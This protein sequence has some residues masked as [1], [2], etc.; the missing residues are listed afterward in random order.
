MQSTLSLGTL[1]GIKLRIHISWLVIFLL[2]TFSLASYFSMTQVQWSVA[3]RL[4][5]AIIAA[6]LFFSSVVIHELAHSLLARRFG[7]PVRDITL[8]LFGGVSQIESEAKRPAEEFWIA[9]VGPLTSI[10]L[11]GLAYLVFLVAGM[12]SFI[13]AISFWLASV[14]LGL[15]IFNLLPAFPLDGGRVLRGLLWWK[16]GDNYRATRIAANF[17]KAI[18]ILLIASGFLLYLRT[19]SF[20]GMWLSFIGWFL[21]NGA[22]AGARQVESDETLKQI[23]AREV[24]SHDYTILSP[25]LKVSD[26][27]ESYLLRSG[28]RCFL[29]GENGQSY[30]LITADDLKRVETGQWQ[31][32][33]I[34][35]LMR[36]FEHIYRATPDIT[37]DKLL[38]I[39]SKENLDYVPVVEDGR[40]AGIVS[41]EQLLAV[42][43]ARKEFNP[44]RDQDRLDRA[45]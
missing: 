44:V 16:T 25:W 15:A 22:R 28:R 39:M 11:A 37:G 30:G 29:V 17:G 3:V 7:I 14:N 5:A 38:E 27:I 19:G 4:S 42:V 6:L 18:A 41:R 1:F 24:M 13:G 20:S 35:D 31:R 12:K 33:T 2:V 10:A 23:S 9:L 8:F 36:T 32:L 26:F 34:G 21:L 43:K 40:L 45:A